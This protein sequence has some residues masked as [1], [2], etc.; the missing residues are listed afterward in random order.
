MRRLARSFRFAFAGLGHLLR[1]QQN[2]RIEVVLGAA[3]VGLGAWLR[4]TPVEWA[5]LAIVIA[6]VLILEGV[7]TSLELAVD[8]ASPR[9]DPRAKAAKDIAA[10]T[11][12]VAALASIAVAL[13]LFLPR[14]ANRLTP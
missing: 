10:S 2:F 6:L 1:T 7:N 9:I 14:L 12:L 3:A 13:A 11:V 4:L 5:A 8:L